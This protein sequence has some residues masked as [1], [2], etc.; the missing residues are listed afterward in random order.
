M[1]DIEMLV[2]W[3]AECDGAIRPHR[4]GTVW[5]TP[6]GVR[7]WDVE[8]SLLARKRKLSNKSVAGQ[9]LTHPRLSSVPVPDELP[10]ACEDHKWGVVPTAEILDALAKGRRSIVLKIRATAQRGNS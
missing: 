7:F 3:C 1:T 8:D 5:C 2:A 10:A 9:V 6:E 4:L